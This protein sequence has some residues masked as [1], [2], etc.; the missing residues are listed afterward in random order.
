MV[1]V[2]CQRPLQSFAFCADALQI[3]LSVFFFVSL[4][5]SAVTKRISLKSFIVLVAS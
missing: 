4:E 3:Q 1:G 5:N 2:Y